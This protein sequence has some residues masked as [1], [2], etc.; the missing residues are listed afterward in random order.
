M[1]TFLTWHNEGGAGDEDDDSDG[2]ENDRDG[3]WQEGGK[4][5]GEIC[6]GFTSHDGTVVKVFD[7]ITVN[8]SVVV[9]EKT[10]ERTLLIKRVVDKV[11]K[12]VE[13]VVETTGDKASKK[14][15]ASSGGGAGKKKHKNKN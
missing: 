7:K 4:D 3:G 6:T 8:I 2:G 10:T 13:T 14:R 9:D 5:E 1:D 11:G 12:A 15:K